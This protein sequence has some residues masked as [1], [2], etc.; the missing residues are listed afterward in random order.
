MLFNGVK[1]DHQFSGDGLVRAACGQHPEHFQLAA[2]QRIDD[3]GPGGALAGIRRGRPGAEGTPQLSQVAERDAGGHVAGALGRDKPAEQRG[4][5]RPLVGEDPDIALWAGEY[6]RAGQGRDRASRIA[7]RRQRQGPQRA[8]LNE[9]A[10]PVL[11]R[12]RRVQPVQQGERLAGPVLGQQDPGQD[13]MLRLA[14]VTGS[15]PRAEAAA[16]RPARGSGQVA[17][18]QQQP[19]PLGGDRVEQARRAW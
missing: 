8:N 2:G 1:G 16:L 18:S 12:C 7:A 11:G 10:G 3:P 14:E 19:R 4:H 13:Q 17:L 5:R 15:V 6:E 9:A